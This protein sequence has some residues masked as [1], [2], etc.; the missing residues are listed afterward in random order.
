VIDQAVADHHMHHGQRKRRVASGFELHVPVS[1]LS[2][3]GSD[4]IDDH[5]LRTASLRFA[6]QRPQVQVRDDRVGS[7]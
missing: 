5:D 4:R 1:S 6:D 2:G 3:A 7:P